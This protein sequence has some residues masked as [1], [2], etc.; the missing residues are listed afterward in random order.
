M[1]TWRALTEQTTYMFVY[2]RHSYCK[3]DRQLGGGPTP[4]SIDNRHSKTFL[5]GLNFY[6]KRLTLLVASC[7]R[8][9]NERPIR[10]CFRS[11]GGMCSNIVNQPLIHTNS[12]HS[13][14]SRQE[15]KCQFVVLN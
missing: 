15:A 5:C 2:S 10:F 14:C 8:A 13:R 4:G 12:S 11:E 7:G 3:S 6:A 9:S 1:P